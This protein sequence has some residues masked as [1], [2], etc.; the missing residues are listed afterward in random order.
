MAPTNIMVAG[1]MPGQAVGEW[2]G[3]LLW[4]G[5]LVAGMA[6]LCVALVW[7]TQEERVALP[8]GSYRRVPRCGPHSPWMRK[9][10]HLTERVG[11][12]LVKITGPST[13]RSQEEGRRRARPTGGQDG[14]R[15]GDTQRTGHPNRNPGVSIYT[16][17]GRLYPTVTNLDSGA[18][19]SVYIDDILL[20]GLAQPRR[21]RDRPAPPP[22]TPGLPGQIVD[23]ESGST[24]PYEER[25]GSNS[26]TRTT[27]M[28]VEVVRGRP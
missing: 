9:L 18:N 4:W 14:P 11:A 16:D 17:R 13:G 25:L 20:T 6:A 10:R 8:S 26:R 7:A 3:T 12:W 22:G 19:I 1:S 5:G 27:N 24:P 21:N 15:R 2:V 23:D 28:W